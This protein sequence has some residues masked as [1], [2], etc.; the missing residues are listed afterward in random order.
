MAIHE[1]LDR[2]G[3]AVQLI[4][5]FRRIDNPRL[6]EKFSGNFNI[7][8]KIVPGTLYLYTSGKNIRWFLR[9]SII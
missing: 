6:F 3:G 5:I 2:D 7:T 1:H 9:I 8:I 4:G